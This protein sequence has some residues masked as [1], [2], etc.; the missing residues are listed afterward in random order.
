MSE[1]LNSRY[2][3]TGMVG[4]GSTSAV[5]RALDTLRPERLA[6]AI[7]QYH[8]DREFPATEMQ[9]LSSLS[10]PGIPHVYEAF[11]G[12]GCWHMVMDY[13]DGETL[14]QCR[15]DCGGKLPVVE[16]AEIGLQL[17]S[18]LDHVHDHG[19][20]YRDLKPQNI[21][22]TDAGKIVLVDFG[23]VSATS[24]YNEYYV[25]APYA[26]P[27]QRL[28]WPEIDERADIYALG[29]ILFQ[30]LFGHC[31]VEDAR[32]ETDQERALLSAILKMV[33]WRPEKRLPT[34]LHVMREL[35]RC[36]AC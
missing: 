30:L 18:L 5:Y 34:M 14:S 25:C 9:H 12:S 24:D 15:Q 28:A 22:R 27:E 36:G 7:K 2:Q 20:V 32:T 29:I 33:S 8:F 16:V 17:A 23:S 19:L 3:I 6:V 26:S 35:L 21:L 11:Y 31:N 10:H 13:V 4:T 1:L